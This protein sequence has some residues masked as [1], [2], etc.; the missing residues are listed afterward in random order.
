M[1]N[2]I[3]EVQLRNEVL[4]VINTAQMMEV[5][6]KDQ[7]GGAADFLKNVK[8]MKKKVLDYWKPLRENAYKA[9]KSIKQKETEFV[10]P[11]DIAERTVKQKMIAYQREEE[12]KRLELQRKLQAEA[13]AKA[14]RERE[15]LMKQA[16]KVKT[17]EKKQEYFEKAE[18]VIAPTVEVQMEK[19][20]VKGIS[21]R[22]TWKAKVIDKRLFIQ[23]AIKNDTLLAFVEIDLKKLNK[24]AQ[25]TKGEVKYPGIEFYVEETLAA[26][27]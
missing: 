25:A 12:R 7:Y 4:P 3:N 17:P 1:A 14:R 16:E 24:F 5:K 20:D 26:R 15:R 22:K 23:E 10:E 6:T 2:K 21:T 13:E 11:L 9:W 18:E 27:S 8:A 19:P